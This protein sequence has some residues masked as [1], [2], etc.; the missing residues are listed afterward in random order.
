MKLIVEKLIEQNGLIDRYY[1]RIED[2]NMDEIF[3]VEVSSQEWEDYNEGDEW[4]QTL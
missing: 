1:L 3:L 4:K 2:T